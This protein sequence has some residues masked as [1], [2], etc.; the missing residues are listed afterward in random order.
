MSPDVF[1]TLA[2]PQDIGNGG[3]NHSTIP[4]IQNIAVCHLET[5]L[6]TGAQRRFDHL[7]HWHSELNCDAASFQ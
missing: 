1:F 7:L 3:E 5:A 2:T 6:G 4:I